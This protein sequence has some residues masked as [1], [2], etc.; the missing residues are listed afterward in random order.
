MLLTHPETSSRVISDSHS[1]LKKGRPSSFAFGPVMT[2]ATA[3][4]CLIHSIVQQ[5][6]KTLPLPV[7]T[8][9]W[10]ARSLTRTQNTSWQTVKHMHTKCMW[11]TLCYCSKYTVQKI[12]MAWYELAFMGI[13]N[14]AMLPNWGSNLHCTSSGKPLLDFP[15]SHPQPFASTV[16][17]RDANYV[18]HSRGQQ[19]T[20][21]TPPPPLCSPRGRQQSGVR[22]LERNVVTTRRR[23]VGSE[24]GEKVKTFIWRQEST[25]EWGRRDGGMWGG[26]EGG[27]SRVTNLWNADSRWG[28]RERNMGKHREWK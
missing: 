14:W 8:P 13:Q 3:P 27:L 26:V 12:M 22:N 9:P 28:E 19:S 4:C 15:T 7:L 25:V 10:R 20:A 11:P 1:D 24:R 23:R 17:A 6:N 21:D 5:L 2:L 18:I 16:N